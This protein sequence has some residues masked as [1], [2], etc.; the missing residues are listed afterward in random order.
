MSWNGD[1]WWVK[2]LFTP[3]GNDASTMS[4]AHMVS[5]RS[6]PFSDR[7]TAEQFAIAM[8]GSSVC[9]GCLVERADESDPD[10]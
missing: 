5:F 1:E 7:E 10:D 9:R 2:V 4:S 3:V 6:G 8:A